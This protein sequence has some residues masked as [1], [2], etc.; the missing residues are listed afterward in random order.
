MGASIGGIANP[1]I[2]NR[3]G[4]AGGGTGIG[5]RT[6]AGVGAGASRA[7]CAFRARI[8]LRRMLEITA[9]TTTM[10]QTIPPMSCIDYLGGCG[11]GCVTS[12]DVVPS[13]LLPIESRMPVSACR[14]LRR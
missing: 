10:I 2:A 1:L 9:M 4:A 7:R 6:G 5:A 3:D 12:G 14:F 8:A 11:G 13:T